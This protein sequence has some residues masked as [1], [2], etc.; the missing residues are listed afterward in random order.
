M[1]ATL[2]ARA[3]R[4]GLLE[5]LHRRLLAG[6]VNSTD[7]VGAELGERSTAQLE[8]AV[9]ALVGLLDVVG[10]DDSDELEVTITGSVPAETSTAGE[11]ALEL[12]AISVVRH[13]APA[14]EAELEEAP[15]EEVA[16]EA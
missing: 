9:A 13:A 11:D 3:A 8:A 10:V 5:E 15:A 6:E 2:Y 4:P 16:P 12:L 1:S 7:V 14:E